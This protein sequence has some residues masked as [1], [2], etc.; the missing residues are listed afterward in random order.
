MADSEICA[1][2]RRDLIPHC[3]SS[4]DYCRS[5]ISYTWIRKSAICRLE[6]QMR[7]SPTRA[8]PLAFRRPDD[9]T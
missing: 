9:F 1:R 8:G 6:Y 2:S 5:G 4:T 7:S 3:L